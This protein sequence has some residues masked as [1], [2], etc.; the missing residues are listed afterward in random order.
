MMDFYDTKQVTQISVASPGEFTQCFKS[1]PS[2]S[3][4]EEL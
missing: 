1:N 4:A 2:D 3:E